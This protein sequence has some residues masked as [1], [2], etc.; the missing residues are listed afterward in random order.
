MQP[1]S[2]STTTCENQIDVYSYVGPNVRQ[3]EFTGVP[4]WRDA[5]SVQEIIGT[6]GTSTRTAL[7]SGPTSNMVTRTVCV[8]ESVVP[9]SGG[10]GSSGTTTIANAPLESLAFVMIWFIVACVTASVVYLFSR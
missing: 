5:Q 6:V 4:M 8:T 9:E 3:Y 1:N 10:G 2:F 7:N